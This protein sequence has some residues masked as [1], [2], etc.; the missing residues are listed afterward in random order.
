VQDVATPVAGDLPQ[1]LAR[2]LDENLLQQI[3]CVSSSRVKFKRNAN[4]A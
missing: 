4:N 3:A 1:R 2:Q